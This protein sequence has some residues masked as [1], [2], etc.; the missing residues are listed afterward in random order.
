MASASL[1][2]RLRSGG[3]FLLAVFI[4]VV[5][6]LLATMIAAT[7]LQLI[8]GTATPPSRLPVESFYRP[9]H[10]LLLLAAFGGLLRLATPSQPPLA[11]Q[12]LPF[13]KA[14]LRQFA[15][16]CALG[17]GLITLAV[18]AIKLIGDFHF[19]ASA[20]SSH[21]ISGTFLV[22]WVLLTAAMLEEVMFR[23][24]PFQRLIDAIGPIAAT[25][26]LSILFGAIHAH[27]PAAT[28][29]GIINTMLVGVLFSLAYLKTKALWLPFGIHFA[30]NATMG[31]VFGLPV[32]GLTMFA[33][34]RQGIAKGSEALTGGSYGIEAS[35]TGTIVILMGILVLAVYPSAK[36]APEPD[37]PHLT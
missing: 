15:H 10:L 2:F 12:G 20:A 37:S 3:L 27:N 5:T 19:A 36:M 4:F 14:S 30:W 9:A 22:I 28:L 33:A 7:S 18:L 23:G 34:V 8:T 35:F 11:G 32:S 29:F 25:A 24:Y 31:L 21:P 17:L 1:R 6:E 26:L 13:A 16:G